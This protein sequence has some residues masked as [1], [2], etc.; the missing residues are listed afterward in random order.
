MGAKGRAC[1][2]LPMPAS[3]I[4]EVL[5]TRGAVTESQHR[6]HAV[7][8]D[9]T[10]R[11]VARHGDPDRTVFPRSAVKPIQ[12]VP[13]VASGAFDALGLPEGF[14]A[15]ACASH[16]GEARHVATASRWLAALGLDQ[17]AFA[18]GAHW[19]SDEV[20]ARFLA[21]NGTEPGRVHNNCSGKHC[22]FLSL[23]RA[24]G[25]PF[26]GYERPEHPVQREVA[27]ALHRFGGADPDGAPRG[28]DGCAV[29]TWALPLASFALGFARLGASQAG[30]A[31]GLGDDDARAA[32]RIGRA[33]ALDPFLVAGTGAFATRA[34]EAGRETLEDGT[35]RPHLLIKG[36][37]EGVYCLALPQAGLGIAVKAEDGAGRA[38]S[39]AV[40]ALA[41]RH[42]G[43]GLPE[44]AR[45]VLAE[46]AS[47]T[48][49]N[50]RGEAVGRIE[51]PFADA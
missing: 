7:V 18:C 34:M 25:A 26:A 46:E 10:G 1:N 33:M 47:Q 5:V 29:P 4:L 20:A 9:A 35:L 39:A 43:A 14:L 36:G 50:T 12:A 17:S 41:L 44:A 19:P 51:A 22:G 37:A 49:R 15:L 31:S 24:L 8:V 40:A 23:A 3:P 13:L 28:V 32:A 2:A 42:G 38:A 6:L 48:L 11:T 30:H 45:R 27:R 16:R 21:R